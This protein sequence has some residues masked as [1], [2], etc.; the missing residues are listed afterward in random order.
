[1]N[2]HFIELI[3]NLTGPTKAVIIT[4]TEVKMNKND[5]L[6]K[7]IKNPY[8]GTVKITTMVVDLNPQYEKTVNEQLSLEGKE[9]DFEV[10]SRKWGE[11]IGNGII[12]KNGKQYVSFIPKKHVLT[13]YMNGNVI[14][15]KN[16]LDPFMPK[17]KSI[18]KQGTENS[19]LFRNVSLE[20][21]CTIELI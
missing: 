13:T 9:Q 15:D 19:V 6:T 21:I 17:G 8:L 5:T 1:M 18:N 4:R 20:N 7:T 11:N 2:Q 3:K 10:S 12:E 16:D 14:I